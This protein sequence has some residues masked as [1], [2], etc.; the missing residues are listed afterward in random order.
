MKAG[1]LRRYS[2]QAAF[3]GVAAALLLASSALAAIGWRAY[4][5]ASRQALRYQAYKAMQRDAGRA[6]S[7]F[8]AYG[9]VLREIREFREAL[10]VQNQGS[11]VLNA[12]VEDARKMDLAISGINALDEIPFP[13]YRELPFELDLA[14]GFANLVRYLHALETRGMAL[15]VR[16]LSA[17]ADAINKSRITAELEL[18]VFVPGADGVSEAAGAAAPMA[19]APAER[20][21]APP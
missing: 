1:S 10:P 18:S 21:E 15:E 6:D 14:G 16:K 5:E 8:S 9:T 17:H 20:G 2:G 4:G 3:L 11:F 19:G 7:L 13:G 12:L